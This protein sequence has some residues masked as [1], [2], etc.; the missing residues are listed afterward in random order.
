HEG[1][2]VSLTATTDAAS[3]TYTW[4]VNGTQVQTGSAADFSFT[5]GDNGPYVVDL[6]VNAGE[7]T[8]SKTLTVDTVAPT[9]TI[10]GPTAA[11]HGQPMTFTLTA[12][13]VAADTAAGFTY[14]IDW[15]GNGTVDETIPATP[16]NASVQVTHTFDANNTYTVKV[17]AE[18]KDHGV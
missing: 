5:P 8:A 18:D 6:S 3:P 9:V 1:S 4:S 7:A 16:G 14:R 2:A 12:A 10:S 17:T 15:D 11:V 13:D